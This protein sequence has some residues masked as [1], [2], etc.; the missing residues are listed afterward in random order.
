[1]RNT[2]L[3]I[4]VCLLTTCLYSQHNTYFIGHSGFGW[5]LMVGE[6]VND[7]AE[8]AGITTY[9]Y[10]YQQIGGSC[11]SIQWERHNDPDVAGSDSHIELATGEYDVVVIAEQIPISEV[12]NSSPWGCDLTSYDALDRFYDLAVGANPGAQVYLM[13]FWNEFDRSDQN[14]HQAWSDLNEEL[15]P[16]WMHVIDSVN[17][18]NNGP[19]IRL[20]PVAPVMQAL[21]DSINLGVVPDIDDWLELF[22]PNDMVE[23]TIHPT[24]VGYYLVA[25]VH[26]A[27]IFRQSPVGLTNET[28]HG[29][30][31]Q[32]DPP[33]QALALKMQEITW[34]VL[35]EDPG[36]QQEVISS[37]PKKSSDLG[38]GVKD[39]SLEIEVRGGDYDK[40]VIYNLNGKV[41]DTGKI[42]HHTKINAIPKGI[43]IVK[44]SGAT[45]TV[46]KKVLVRK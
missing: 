22:D 25:L 37:L 20:V 34:A 44:V 30:G 8:D 1:M 14:A 28:F 43:F 33:S 6:M 36:F 11:I 46:I 3:G 32:F 4:V 10:N 24:E 31:W 26:F 2:A 29:D 41:F 9:D 7:L 38:I 40:Y 21:K 18:T 19:D 17:S 16:L 13:G 35:Q 5:D 12:I 39:N 42:S 45:G 27:V 23:A 15:R